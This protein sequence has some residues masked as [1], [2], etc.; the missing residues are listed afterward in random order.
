MYSGARP[1]VLLLSTMLAGTL[2]VTGV[3]AV[4]GAS[5]SGGSADRG[6]PSSPPA[7]L[8]RPVGDSGVRSLDRPLVDADFHRTPRG[9][10]RTHR[11]R[12]SSYSLVGLTW[13]GDGTRLRMRHR[14]DRGW[15]AWTTMPALVDRPSADS[16]D[17]DGAAGTVG[18]E[19]VWVG[20]SDAVQVSL[21][22]PLPDHLTLVLIDPGSLPSDTAEPPPAERPRHHRH[23][24]DHAPRPLIRSR[25][26]WG[27]KESWRD[28]GPWYDR[29]IQQVHVHHTV[30]VNGYS[31]ADVPALIRGM[32]RYHTHDLGWSDIG[33]N[34]LV[35]RFGRIWEGRHGGAGLAVQ[36]AHTLGFNETSTGIS[37][38]GDFETARPSQ[39]VLTAIVRL[40]AW[41][42]DKY[43]VRVRRWAHVFSHGSDR[44]PYGRMVTLPRVDGHRDTNETACPGRYLYARLPGI[45]RRTALRVHRFS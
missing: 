24:P 40:A 21:R 45:R 29:T 13:R 5:A 31:R 30:S 20:A 38:I 4:P 8:L 14:T 36:G 44:F 28:G 23:R 17:A 42:L 18:T 34:F 11:L 16:P 9:G 25:H 12:A 2:L 32:Y 27:A 43:H 41:K 35:D 33:Y 26:S 10:R 1:S 3:L 37:V 39:R 7:L 6:K 19:P 15:S 22:G